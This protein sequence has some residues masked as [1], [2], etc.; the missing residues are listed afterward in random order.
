[1][2]CYAATKRN[3]VNFSV[4]TREDVYTISSYKKYTYTEGHMG[5]KFPEQAMNLSPVLWKHGVLTTGPPEKSQESPV[6]D[7]ISIS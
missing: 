7:E 1:M 5:S 3:G 4:L 2:D 6:L